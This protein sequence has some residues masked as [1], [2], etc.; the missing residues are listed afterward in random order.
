METVKLTPLS[1]EEK[2]S[3]ISF[4]GKSVWE[5]ISFP[6]NSAGYQNIT[7]QEITNKTVAQLESYGTFIEKS[8]LSTGSRFGKAKSQKTWGSI[9]VNELVTFLELVIKNKEYEAEAKRRESK[10]KFIKDQ[11]ENLKTPEERK[12]ELEAELA[13]LESEG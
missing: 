3:V 8:Y 10:A 1:K 6:S 5:N 7:V 4:I 9:T 12:K 2:E 13:G 11:L